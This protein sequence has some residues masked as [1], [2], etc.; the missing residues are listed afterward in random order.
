MAIRRKPQNVEEFIERG[1]DVAGDASLHRGRERDFRNVRLRIAKDV[2][3]EI[4]AAIAKRRS[5]ISR[6]TWIMEAIVEKLKQED[7]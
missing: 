1:G 3:T 6:H 7:S 5:G 4:D 2:L